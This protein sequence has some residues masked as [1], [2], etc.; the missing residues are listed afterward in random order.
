[1]A[2]KTIKTPPLQTSNKA[3]RGYK[4]APDGLQLLH[5]LLFLAGWKV[6]DPR[7]SVEDLQRLVAGLISGTFHKWGTP[8]SSMFMGFS[9]VNHPVGVPTFMDT[10]IFLV[11]SKK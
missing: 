6:Y 7:I 2:I 1:M 5:L 3:L 8:K 10:H 9:L 11:S 4:V